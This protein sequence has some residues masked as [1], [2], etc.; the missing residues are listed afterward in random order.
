LIHFYKRFRLKMIFDQEFIRKN[1][2]PCLSFV[3]L[4]VLRVNSILSFVGYKLE[5]IIHEDFASKKHQHTEA[6]RKLEQLKDSERKKIR[7]SVDLNP[8]NRE[9]KVPNY[10]SLEPKINFTEDLEG[11]K[12]N[13]LRPDIVPSD[14]FQMVESDKT[15]DELKVNETSR[16]STTSE[17]SRESD[18]LNVSECEEVVFVSMVDLSTKSFSQNGSAQKA[19]ADVP[20]SNSIADVNGKTNGSTNSDSN[21]DSHNLDASTDMQEPISK[22]VEFVVNEIHDLKQKRNAVNVSSERF[23][24]INDEN[25]DFIQ[26]N[27]TNRN[28]DQVGDDKSG[29]KKKSEESRS[30]PVKAPI[31]NGKKSGGG[32]GKTKKKAA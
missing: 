32:K 16:D 6:K 21:Y 3:L 31:V 24:D 4:Q 8:A 20:R 11:D 25:K 23:M 27:P 12:L 14:S 1:I 13:C 30:G 9:D 18:D 7:S 17:V 29:D 2:T 28:Q 15:D 26:K 22:L 10:W 19:D 5:R